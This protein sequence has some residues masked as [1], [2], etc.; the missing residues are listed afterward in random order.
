MILDAVDELGWTGL[1]PVDGAFY[2]YAGIEDQLRGDHRASA[3]WAA[4][5]L[6]T[7][8]VAVTP[9][10]DF[11]GIAGDAWIRLSL[12]AGPAAVSAAVDRILAFQHGI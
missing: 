7:H 8:G 2:V 5:L 4:A 9:G 6:D 10:L 11:D 3:D 12:A 1:A